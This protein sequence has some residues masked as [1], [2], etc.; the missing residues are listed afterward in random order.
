M[1]YCPTCANPLALRVLEGVE[2]EACTLP[3]CQYIHWDN[4]VPVVAAL[5]QYRDHVILARNAQWPSPMFS[6]ITGYLERNESPEQAVLREVHEELG[7]QGQV[8]GF[9]GH[10]SVFKNNQ[11][12]LAYWVRADGQLK[13]DKEIAEVRLVSH[14]QLKHYEFGELTITAQIVNEYL[15]KI[16]APA[17]A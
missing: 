4:P 17:S 15:Q 6:L 5:V 10:Y 9:I 14:D 11:L 1:K 12:L 13:L 3:T 2:R 7:L 16:T 8:S